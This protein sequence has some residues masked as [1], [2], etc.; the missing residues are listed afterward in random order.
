MPLNQNNNLSSPDTIPLIT[1]AWV[2]GMA[3]LGGFVSFMRKMKE[4][5]V[6]VWNFAE[7]IGE[8]ATSAFAGVMAFYFCQWSGFPDMLTASAVGVSGHM[9]SKA[10]F[11]AERFF[12]S[13]FPKGKG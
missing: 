10:I 13:K 6:R 12:E 1:Y 5:H 8:M 4:G 9:G 2:F 3:F 7:F 11:L